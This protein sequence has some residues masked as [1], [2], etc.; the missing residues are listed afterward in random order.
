[1]LQVFFQNQW[2]KIYRGSFLLPLFLIF[3]VSAQEEIGLFKRF[4]DI[5]Q[6][7]DKA[8]ARLEARA[9]D[10][11]FSVGEIENFEDIKINL[12]YL[13][14]VML[15]TP[16]RYQY[17]L[18]RDKCS[19]Y[20]IL[21]TDL[22]ELPEKY[23]QT[24]F[25]DFKDKKNLVKT[26]SLPRARFFKEIVAKICPGVI[27]ISRNFDAA[28][29]KNTLGQ[30]KLKFP[31]NKPLCEQYFEDFRSNVTAPYLC[32]LIE[33]IE[34]LPSW[35]AQNR[36]IKNQNNIT[37]RREL[38]AKVARA[39]QY[40]NTL[41]PEVYGKLKK[42]C[43][44]LDNIDLGCSELFLENYWTYLFKEKRESPIMKTYCG[45]KVNA[46]CLATLSKET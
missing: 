3:P 10:N 39:T 46:N 23:R 16:L 11:P 34:N 20:D 24:I 5:L 32:H 40:K 6:S 41:S 27:K 43:N 22:V 31:E 28:N 2:N 4:N 42:T 44:Y 45:D 25:F 21:I 18:T 17:F 35:E 38:Q 30:L 1:M 36:S 33:N 37:L 19:L 15:N 9:E 12:D 14:F 29:L 8:F 13:N 26:S 7:Q